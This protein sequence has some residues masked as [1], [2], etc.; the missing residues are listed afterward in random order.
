MLKI[1]MMAQGEIIALLLR[2]HYGH[3]A[4]ARD[5]NPYVVPMN[6]VFDAQG[7]YFFTT[8]GTK[9]EYMAAN[10]KVCFQV[11]EITDAQRWR[12]VMVT[13]HAERVSGPAESERAMSLI[14]ERN[15]TLTPALNVTK[16][17][18]WTRLNHVVIYRIRPAA[19]YGRKTD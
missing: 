5:D 4:C 8:E 13:G 12:S 7:L 17:G 9:T 6:Y 15:P 19:F 16:I 18:A 3:L 2:A 14:V 10:R 1:A 11:E